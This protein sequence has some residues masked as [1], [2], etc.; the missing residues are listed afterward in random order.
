MDIN[1]EFDKLQ[2]EYLSTRSDKAIYESK[3][4]SILCSVF[5]ISVFLYL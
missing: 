1:E 3:T 2:T 4:V 5:G